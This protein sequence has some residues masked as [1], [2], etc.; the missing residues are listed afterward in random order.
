MGLTSAMASVGDCAMER[1][2]VGERQRAPR[3]FAE[4]GLVFPRPPRG[5]GGEENRPMGGGG[6]ART[7]VLSFTAWRWLSCARRI[8]GTTQSRSPGRSRGV[9]T[10]AGGLSGARAGVGGG[11]AVAQLF[12]GWRRSAVRSAGRYEYDRP[13][14]VAS[15][16]RRRVPLLSLVSSSTPLPSSPPTGRDVPAMGPKRRRPGAPAPAPPPGPYRSKYDDGSLPPMPPPR[17]PPAR[18]RPT[19]SPPT[20]VRSRRRFT[21]SPSAPCASSARAVRAPAR[22]WTSAPSP[23]GSRTGPTPRASSPCWE[24]P[25]RAPSSPIATSSPRTRW[26]TSR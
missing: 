3:R 12:D 1:R 10:G 4:E 25:R 16:P 15:R 2:G 20:R 6:R 11:G 22:A 13:V 21:A 26:A 8:R 17:S 14:V 23:R 18:P 19:A 5:R 24:G 7:H 9:R